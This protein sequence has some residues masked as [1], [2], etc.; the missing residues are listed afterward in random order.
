[1]IESYRFGR[2]TVQGQTYR[3]DITIIGQ[4]VFPCW[5]RQSGHLVTDGD[6]ADVLDYRPD[7]LVIGRGS[8]GMMHVH[9]SLSALC[10]D[11]GIE[12]ITRRTGPAVTAFN[13]LLAGKVT[14]A[15]AF[16]LT[17]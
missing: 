7:I 14:V 11:R 2:I 4:K 9:E 16:H 15:G 6:L 10:G 1:M 5:R 17:C 8:L 13:A 3:K 12:L